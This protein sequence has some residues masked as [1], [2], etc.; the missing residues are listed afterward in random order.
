M[1]S[2]AVFVAALACSVVFASDPGQPAAAGSSGPPASTDSKPAPEVRQATD[3]DLIVKEW[4]SP[5]TFEVDAAWLTTL[6][7]GGAKEIDDLPSFHCDSATL[8]SLKVTT[9]K[10]Q[11]GIMRLTIEYVLSVQASTHDKL[12]DL[13]FTLLAGNTRLP[14]GRVSDL[15][16]AEGKSFSS[17]VRYDRPEERFAPYLAEGSTPRIRVSMI[18]RNQ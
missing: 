12:I 7:L 6:P 18:V 2:T 5:I 8:A 13:E 9:A 3:E 4:H 1:R 17:L 16:V 10:P 15:A 14:L 11:P